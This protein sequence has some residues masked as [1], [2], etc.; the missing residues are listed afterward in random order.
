MTV[1]YQ[2]VPS[3]E[4]A[5]LFAAD[6]YSDAPDETQGLKT[7]PVFEEASIKERGS[8]IATA[9]GLALGMH[10]FEAAGGNA[11][12][13]QRYIDGV[14]ALMR[15]TVAQLDLQRPAEPQGETP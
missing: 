12:N 4:I 13:A 5:R 6:V 7:S 1:T 15:E 8:A 2:G 3:I 10:A 14:L 11:G 9:V